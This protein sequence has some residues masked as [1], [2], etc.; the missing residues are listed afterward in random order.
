MGLIARVGFCAFVLLAG[1]AVASSAE[2]AEFSA[3]ELQKLIALAEATLQATD[4]QKQEV[5]RG[6]PA[7]PLFDQMTFSEL[8]THF[9]EPPGYIPSREQRGWK[10]VR[11]FARE[12]LHTHADSAKHKALAEVF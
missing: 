1:A 9:S 10:L 11:R 6:V 3:A 12:L 8:K 7:E 4:A 2:P 5:G